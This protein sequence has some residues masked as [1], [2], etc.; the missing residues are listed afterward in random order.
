MPSGALQTTIQRCTDV[1]NQLGSPLGCGER[2]RSS[3]FPRWPLGPWPLQFCELINDLS[4]E[5]TTHRLELIQQVLE[6]SGYVSE[7]IAE[8]TDEAEE[9]RRN[10]QELVNAALQYHRKTMK[11]I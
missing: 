1:P 5:S 7:L 11:V 4:S 9:R 10:L 6:K 2:S 3:P 8:G